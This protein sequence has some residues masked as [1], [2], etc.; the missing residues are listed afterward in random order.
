MEKVSDPHQDSFN[1]LCQ[2]TYHDYDTMSEHVNIPS[3][4]QIYN[5]FLI[6][7]NIYMLISINLKKNQY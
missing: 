3:R 1:W 5:N 2:E 4:T 7:L 6:N